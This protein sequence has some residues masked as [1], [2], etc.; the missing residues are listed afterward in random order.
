MNSVEWS[1]WS[2]LRNRGSV[3]HNSI[4]ENSHTYWMIDFKESDNTQILSNKNPDLHQDFYFLE[5]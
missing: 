3:F 1:E 2:E 4:H 5:I